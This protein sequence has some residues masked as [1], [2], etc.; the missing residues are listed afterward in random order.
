MFHLLYGGTYHRNK[1]VTR[2]L[3]REISFLRKLKRS[4]G[5]RQ[6]NRGV[7]GPS[8]NFEEGDVPWI[9]KKN[10]LSLAKEVILGVKVPYLYWSTLRHCFTIDE[11]LS[12]VKSHDHLNLIKVHMSKKC[13]Y[14]WFL[15]LTPQAKTQLIFCVFTL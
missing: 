4:I 7:V 6:E 3:S 13:F 12:R 2:W 8:W 5:T 14:F 15:S 10:D 9:L 1:V 11:F